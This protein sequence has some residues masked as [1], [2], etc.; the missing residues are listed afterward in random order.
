MATHTYTEPAFAAKEK[1]VD[2]LLEEFK[3]K[4]V[5][6]KKPKGV[7]DRPQGAAVSEERVTRG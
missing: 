1:F 7:Q 5:L 3:P 2:S 6:D 4:R